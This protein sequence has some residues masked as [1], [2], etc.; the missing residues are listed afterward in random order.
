VR[1]ASRGF[2]TPMPSL[3][4]SRQITSGLLPGARELL[5]WLSKSGI[6]WAIATSGRMETAAVNLASLGVDPGGIP[7]VTRDRSN[8]PSPILTVFWR[9]PNG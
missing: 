4:D 9:P 7:V 2:A 5:N 6:P 3:T 1:N 8:M